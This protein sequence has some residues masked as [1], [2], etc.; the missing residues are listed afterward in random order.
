[1]ELNQLIN[2]IK[3]F[4][5]YKYCRDTCKHLFNNT[6]NKQNKYNEVK[7]SL[8]FEPDV[9]MFLTCFEWYQVVEQCHFP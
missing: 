1:M 6:W 9:Q 5:I 8:S 4:I 7:S 2:D 3:L